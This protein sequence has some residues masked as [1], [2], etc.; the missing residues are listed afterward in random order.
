MKA[1]TIDTLP[2]FVDVDGDCWLWTGNVNHQGYGRYGK[3]A[4]Y[5]HQVVRELLGVPVPHGLEPD[6][7]CRRRRCVNPDHTEPVTHAENIARGA[8]D[9]RVGQAT[10]AA[11]KTRRMLTEVI[12]RVALD[13]AAR[14]KAGQS[15]STRSCFAGVAGYAGARKHLNH[16]DLVD[17]AVDQLGT[18]V[19]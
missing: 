19:L 9:P 7:L 8:W 14:M 3:R 1:L 5:A 16:S 2:E 15:V 17:M 18:A 6:H 4:R 12:P 10:G 11:T 13:I